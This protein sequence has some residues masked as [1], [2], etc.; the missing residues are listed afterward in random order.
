MI[1][2]ATGWFK[3]VKLPVSQLN[4]LDIPTGT[5]GQGSKDTHI[6]AKQPYFD[7]SSATIG[8]LINRTR[9]SR[10]PCSQYI[11]YNNGSEFKLHF[12]T[13]CNSYGLKRKPTSVR[14]PQVNAILERVHQTIMAMLRRADLDMAD[15]VNASDIVDFLTNAAWAVCSTYHTVLK[16][17]PG[18]AIFEQDS[19]LDHHCRGADQLQALERCVWD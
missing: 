3:I 4:E 15:T 16:T 19:P 1:G 6:Q 2:P 8:N 13:L 17:S 7:K 14:N 10:Y 5:K 9:C 18:A 11:I 12:K